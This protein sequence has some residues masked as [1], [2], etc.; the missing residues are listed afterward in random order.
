MVEIYTK[1]EEFIINNLLIDNLPSKTVENREDLISFCFLLFGI[2]EENCR[3]KINCSR[4]TEKFWKQIK[5]LKNFELTFNNFTERE[6]N[7]TFKYIVYLPACQKFE[8]NLV[9]KTY[10]HLKESKLID[11]NLSIADIGKS[12]MYWLT[13]IKELAR[14]DSLKTKETIEL[15]NFTKEILDYDITNLY[16]NLKENLLDQEK[17]VNTKEHKNVINE[18][19]KQSFIT[20]SVNNSNNS[21]NLKENKSTWE[22]SD[23]KLSSSFNDCASNLKVENTST[24]NNLTVPK[25]KVETKNTQKLISK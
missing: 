1:Q 20:K 17:K 25:N 19:S 5:G 23:N 16:V 6:L 8:I 15:C 3:K 21:L 10:F 14:N 9:L 2:P 11:S 24:V 18:T 12:M 13:K 4:I 22:T 7:N